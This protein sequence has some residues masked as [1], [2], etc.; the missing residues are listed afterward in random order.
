MYDLTDED[1]EEFGEV[2]NRMVDKCY[3]QGICP[4]PLYN[5]CP[6]KHVV[7][8]GDCQFT[9]QEQWIVLIKRLADMEGTI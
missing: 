7:D 2:A 6:F 9:T 4:S 5:A 8:T 3:T 1:F